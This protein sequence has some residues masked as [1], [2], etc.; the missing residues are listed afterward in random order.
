VWLHGYNGQPQ[1]SFYPGK[2]VVDIGGADTYVIT[3]DELAQ[4]QVRGR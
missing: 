4:P 1:S 3:R 2:P